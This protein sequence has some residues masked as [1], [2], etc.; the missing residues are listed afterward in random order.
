MLWS[1]LPEHVHAAV[2]QILGAPVV[3][4][5]SQPGGFSPARPTAS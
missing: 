3:P 4:A 5:H 1:D 2:E